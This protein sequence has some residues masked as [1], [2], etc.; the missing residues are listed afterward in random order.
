MAAVAQAPSPVRPS[1]RTILALVIALAA[2]GI[3]LG[4]LQSLLQGMH[5]SGRPAKSIGSL[6]HLFHPGGDVQTSAGTV[7][8]WKEYE[9][10]TEG[11]GT[12][13][14]HQVAR[15][16]VAVD[17]VLL[18]PLYT[19]GLV[20]LFRRVSRELE[21]NPDRE[22][23]RYYYP[24]AKIGLVLILVGFVAD[25][26]ENVANLSIVE[27]GWS[28]NPH[29]GRGWF[30]T[31]TWV[32]WISGW[33]K[34]AAGL[35]AAGV[36]LLLGWVVFAESAAR[37][38]DGW[39]AIRPRVHLL[40]TQLILVLVVAFVPFGHE[41]IADL[42][43]RW[44]P[45]QLAWTAALVWLFALATWLVGRR[46]LVCGQWEPSWEAHRRKR[47]TR[48]LF[49]TVL[50]L[51]LLQGIADLLS[52][53][54]YRPGWGLA[55]PAVILAALAL[56]GLLLRGHPQAEVVPSGA[57][58]APEAT[59]P[60][61]PRAL[62]SFALV[63]FGLGVLHASFGYSV[64]ARA[65]TW[66]ASS[67]G[68][69]AL[70]VAGVVLAAVLG[71]ELLLGGLLGAVAALVLLALA[72]PDFLAPP[73]LVGAALCSVVGGWRLYDALGRPAVS[74]PKQELSWKAVVVLAI[75]FA[76]GYAA[77]VVRPFAIGE[78]VGGVGIL[79]FFALV[80]TCVGALLVWLVPALHVPR[81]L[82][83]LGVVRFPIMGL[84]VVWFVAAA[85][86]DPGD[87]H[88][89]RLKKADAP[90]TGVTLPVAWHCWLAKNGLPDE[91]SQPN[92]CTPP[93]GAAP[94]A[95]GAV[96][97]I[98][99][100][101]TGGGIR[102]AYWT[103]LVLD[104]AFE[105]NAGS[106]C[107][108]GGHS[109]SFARSDR[110]FA[111]SGISGGSL[112]LASYAAYISEKQKRGP[113]R[114]WVRRSLD[115]DALSASGAWWLLVEFPRVFLE[116]RSPTD[117]AGV[118]ER[119]WEHQ[120]PHGELG[121]GLLD[122][123]RTNHHEPLLLLNGTSVQDG[124]RFE[125]SPLNANVETRAG[126]PPGCKSTELFDE[127]PPDVAGSSV[128]PATRDLLD[129]LCNDRKDVRL[130]TAALLS[131]RFPFVN[132]A[133]RIPGR[134][135]YGGAKT[136]PVA[137][138]VD[139][140]YLDTSGASPILELMTDLQ[141]LVQRWNQD[142]AHAGR[143][144]VPVMIQIDNGFSAGKTPGWPGQL[145][146]PPKTLL[147]SRGAREAEARIGGALAFSGAKGAQDRWAH[148][149]NVAHP[150]PKAPLGWAQSRVSEDELTQQLTQDQ[151]RT[152]FARVARWLRPGGL[153][154]PSGA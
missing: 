50:A 122:L 80:L 99:V 28:S 39:K 89:V 130:S 98:L 36:A 152:E 22:R 135:K 108:T 137:Y 125:T 117:R 66:K 47:I 25:E 58:I 114:N 109:A 46:L 1:W 113:E 52:H 142:K 139:G 119:G 40:R 10:R 144:V 29:Y 138:V 9:A 27:Y 82:T 81:A 26:I 2:A 61:L 116:F 79:L 105:V 76:A 100:A 44:A 97:L 72:Q 48:I 145:L 30:E 38:R 91:S 143:C 53:G 60:R 110:L 86:I 51:A 153:T 104:C 59:H 8:I 54:R 15:W 62:A 94:A 19:L 95:K 42:I 154:C 32:L 112:G 126:T 77:V 148:F 13:G 83:V 7:Q 128:L 23:D 45:E 17:F 16:A 12:A 103:S 121:Q 71:R 115:A 106:A 147:A 146:A 41:Q 127:S 35:T 74:R 21:R 140:G 49:S 75:V 120:W 67:L 70:V 11:Q 18:A 92:D 129:Y 102:A 88:N 73:V 131:G 20:L 123:W 84:L 78:H 43:R 149:V 33:V 56:L 118:L 107:P 134:C 101:T 133:A 96:P 93:D 111:L 24:I 3:A 90:A 151:N 63:V 14:P 150:G 31:L 4:Q 57:A 69:L 64:Y 132:P 87:Y 6:N 141:P 34:W 55:V 65:W 136:A 85:R 68:A 124:C 37:L 5:V